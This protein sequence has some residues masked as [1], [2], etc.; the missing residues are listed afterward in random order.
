MSALP[1]PDQIPCRVACDICG[2]KPARWFGQTSASVC[3]RGECRAEQQRRFSE[4]CAEVARLEAENEDNNQGVS[5]D[6]DE[7]WR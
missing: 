3:E 7:C 4:H 1:A 5:Y 2:A 6:E